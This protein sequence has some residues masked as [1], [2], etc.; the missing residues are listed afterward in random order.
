MERETKM[1]YVMNDNHNGSVVQKAIVF[2]DDKRNDKDIVMAQIGLNDSNVIA[3][4][5]NQLC[6]IDDVPG[7]IIE[8]KLRRK[9]LQE[10]RKNNETKGLKLFW[11]F[12]I[13]GKKLED[14]KKVFWAIDIA[15]ALRVV[16]KK[17]GVSGRAF[18][19]RML[20]SREF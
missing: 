19:D 12:K 13:V 20:H 4:R 15:D 2:I 16:R 3:V 14:L 17:H 9:K 18:S 10:L 5:R 8:I 7:K 1:F 11:I 6:N